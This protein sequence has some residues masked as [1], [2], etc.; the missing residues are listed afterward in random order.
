[1]ISYEPLF[2]T[3]KESINQLCSILHCNVSDVVEY[4]EEEPELPDKR[5]QDST[6]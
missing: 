6:L 5:R 2:Q 1:M 4:I 3:M